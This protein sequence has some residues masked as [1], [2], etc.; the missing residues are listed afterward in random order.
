[1]LRA[2]PSVGHPERGCLHQRAS[3]S[4]SSA[5]LL[6]KVRS[7]SGVRNAE[8]ESKAPDPYV[9]LLSMWRHFILVLHDSSVQTRYS[10]VACSVSSLAPSI[11]VPTCGCN[12]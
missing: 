7:H 1:M 5:I 6:R 3:D 8:S 12:Q 10:C 2:W 4:R 9:P 11:L